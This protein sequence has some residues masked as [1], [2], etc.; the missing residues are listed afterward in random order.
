MADYTINLEQDGARG[1]YVIAL[2]GGQEAEMTF[3]RFDDVM[4]I[5]HTGVPEEFEGHGIARLLLDRAIAD[6]RAQGFK[7]FP[8]CSYVVAQF[9]RHAKEWADVLAT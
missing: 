9:R 2:E 6:V 7:I 3:H 8:A 1:R 4:R 5:T